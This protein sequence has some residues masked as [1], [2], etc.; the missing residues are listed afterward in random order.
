[1]GRFGG[2]GHREGGGFQGAG[3]GERFFL[4][5]DLTAAAIRMCNGQ[6]ELA[7]FVD[8]SLCCYLLLYVVRSMLLW[9]HVT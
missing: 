2:H 4:G 1:M 6:S 5:M 9:L 7:W 3:L 8:W